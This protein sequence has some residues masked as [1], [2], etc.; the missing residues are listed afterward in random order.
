MFFL[1]CSVAA[2]LHKYSFSF[3]FIWSDENENIMLGTFFLLT[4]LKSF[5]FSFLH[6]LCIS[7][8]FV[9]V[10]ETSYYQLNFGGQYEKVKPKMMIFYHSSYSF[11]FIKAIP[12]RTHG[13]FIP[14]NHSFI[15]FFFVFFFY[16]GVGT[17]KKYNFFSFLYVHIAPSNCIS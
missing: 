16:V 5:V 4:M 15:R 17:M 2:T 12:D 9:Q 3:S 10:T 13:V 6:S 7:V 8:L 1:S 14:V 11:P